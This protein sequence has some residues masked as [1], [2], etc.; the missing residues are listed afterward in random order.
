MV[1]INQ[2]YEL[3]D[4]L[5]T[6]NY[7]ARQLLRELRE[8]IELYDCSGAVWT[9]T[10]DVEGE[11]NGLLSYDR[12]VFRADLEMWQEEIQGLYD[13]AEKRGARAYKVVKGKELP[14]PGKGSP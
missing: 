1:T 11:V 3:N 12:R 7:R 5:P 9:Q 6:Y 2:T 14:P 13:A 8:Q 10:T 4:D